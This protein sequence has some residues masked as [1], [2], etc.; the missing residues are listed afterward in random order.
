MAVRYADFGFDAKGI[1]S[2]DGLRILAGSTVRSTTVPSSSKAN[3][4]RRQALLD[5]GT[6]VPDGDLL[7]FTADHLFSTPSGASQMCYGGPSN[8]WR[9]WKTE[10]GHEL[11]ESVNRETGQASD[12]KGPDS[13]S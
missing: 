2:A 13:P 1:W 8:G 4:R 10:D 12:E 11:W 7:R 6:L 9:A 3:L 5:S